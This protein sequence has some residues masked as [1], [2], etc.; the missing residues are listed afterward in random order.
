MATLLHQIHRTCIFTLPITQITTVNQ[1][2]IQ[3]QDSMTSLHHS[4]S[5][6]ITDPPPQTRSHISSPSPQT[7]PRLIT[8][9]IHRRCRRLQNKLLQCPAKLLPVQPLTIQQ[10]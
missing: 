5:A 2:T 3:N 1:S 8:V 6:F 4:H 10:A 7:T 9:P